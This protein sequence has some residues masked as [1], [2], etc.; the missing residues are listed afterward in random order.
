MAMKTKTITRSKEKQIEMIAEEVKAVPPEGVQKNDEY[1]S[2][3]TA[4]LVPLL[5]EEVKEQQKAIDVLFEEVKE[6]KNEI[7][8][9]NSMTMIVTD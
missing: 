8:L 9:K 5:I 1:Y 4:G 2:M 7:K 3:V 6:L